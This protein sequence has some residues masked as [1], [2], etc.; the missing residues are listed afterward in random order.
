MLYT[1]YTPEGKF[2]GA[3]KKVKYHNMNNFSDRNKKLAPGFCHTSHISKIQNVQCLK[4]RKEKK[5]NQEYIRC[6][7]K[8]WVRYNLQ[9]LREVSTFL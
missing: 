4:K 1:A 6:D 2:K 5:N 7:K 3:S 8:I 9:L